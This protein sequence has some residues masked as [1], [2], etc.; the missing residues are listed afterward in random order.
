MFKTALLKN[1]YGGVA[2]GLLSIGLALTLITPIGATQASADT[3]V[4][5]WNI[6]N[7][8]WGEKKDYQALA[9][10]ASRYDL[11]AI[12]E[13]MNED[14]LAKL[15]TE[16]EAKTG[17]QW[18]SLSSHLVGRGQYKEIYA[19]LYRPEKVQWIDGAAVYIDQRDVFEREPFSAHFRTSDGYD[20]VLATAHLIYGDD[21][22]R[23]QFEAQA[24]A[25]YRDWL[26]ESFPGLPVYLSGDFNLPPKDKAWDSVGVSAHPLITKG[27]TT[28]SSNNGKFAN[29]Y[30][31]IW[32]P[33]GTAVPVVDYGV[34]PFPQMI[35]MS[36]AKARDTVSD[37]IPV[38]MV[39][40]NTAQPVSFPAWSDAPAEPMDDPRQSA[41]NLNAAVLGNKNS[42]I[43]HVEGCP[44]FT[45]ISS[46]NQVAFQ[47]EEEAI[48]AGY[49]RAGNCS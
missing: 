24:L 16:V 34:T 35:G 30:D 33:A 36:H 14:A 9:E 13:V 40:D 37:H 10:I 4:A 19:F 25:S 46:K 11:L 41:A 29:L 21:P 18:D 12:Q 39:L 38:W 7:L 28:L 49:R 1:L 23:R 31:N 8:G 26:T 3:V 45:K 5:S 44:G 43:Y 6:R 22:A 17:T 2:R 42:S 32:V 27:A 20:F 15:E 47:T 48:S